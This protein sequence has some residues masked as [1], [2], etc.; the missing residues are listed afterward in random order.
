MA[1]VLVLAACSS[2]SPTAT[3]SP[4]PSPSPAALSCRLPI[5][6]EVVNGP[7]ITPKAGFL[8]FPGQ[9]I[10]E[11]P[12][13]PLGSRFYDRALSRWLPTTRETVSNDGTRYA[14][15]E[16]NAYVSS[17]GRVHVV[18]VTSGVDRVIYSG[19]PVFGVVDFA[20]EG[21]YLT[22]AAA[23]GS[24]RGLWLM[25]PGT[26]AVRLINRTI[27]GPQ[28]GGGAAWGKDFNAAD[29]S[30]GPGGIEGPSN[31]VVRLD[32]RSGAQT[33]WFYLPGTNLYLAGA[34]AAGYPFVIAGRNS[35]SDFST[36]TQELWLVTAPA[37]PTQLFT[38]SASEQYPIRLAAIDSHGIWFDGKT[39]TAA[40]GTVWLYSAGAI[41]VVAT[42]NV[43][44]LQVAGGCI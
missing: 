24:P 37:S 26:G 42:V 5:S 34:D 1:A 38:G 40:P 4:T 12:S 8:S 7:T 39:Y 31:T 10:A 28:V 29:P 11:D 27:D 2:S 25:N 22:G 41:R 44:T 14:Y 30:P 35:G 33:P 32:L 13:A 19:S 16:G 23:E 6:W 3:P 18:D 15:S 43:D 9:T 20:T 36:A 17:Q 21:I